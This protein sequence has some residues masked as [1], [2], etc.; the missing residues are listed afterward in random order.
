[1]S[2]STS[3]ATDLPANAISADLSADGRYFSYTMT[4]GATRTHYGV[5]LAT[6]ITTTVVPAPGMATPGE[7]GID[8]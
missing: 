8:R 4:A 3:R 1:M 5:D 6:G 7:R 2:S